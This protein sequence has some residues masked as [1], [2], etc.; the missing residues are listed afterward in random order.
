M[1]TA[2]TRRSPWGSIATHG[3]LGAVTLVTMYP[4]LI[5]MRIAFSLG[6]SGMSPSLNPIPREL[7][8]DNFVAVVTNTSAQGDWLFGR[9][10]LNSAV[11]A[12]ATTVL[13]AIW[14]RIWLGA[15]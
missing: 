6:D 8:F 4:L 9:Q 10:L 3:I 14:V 7:S 12:I 1:S 11:I 13:G 15:P 5:V 2:T